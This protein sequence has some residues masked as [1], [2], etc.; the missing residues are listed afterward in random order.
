MLVSLAKLL[1]NL[2][3]TLEFKILTIEEPK[4]ASVRGSDTV[5][6][7][8]GSRRGLE[9]TTAKSLNIR[10]SWSKGGPVT[11]GGGKTGEGG[12][13]EISMFLLISKSSKTSAPET[14]I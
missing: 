9:S 11:S 13:K 6:D 2:G 5:G 4:L 1:K 7:S 3:S 10:P 14:G 8:A 12:S